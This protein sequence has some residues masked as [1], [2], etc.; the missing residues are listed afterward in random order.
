MWAIPEKEAKELAKETLH[1]L[2]PIAH[3]LGMNNIKG[4][5]EDLSLRYYKPDIYFSI[6]EKLNRTKKE[7]DDIVKEMIENVSK[8]LNDH[9]IEHK[10]KGRSKSIYSIYKKLDKGKKFEDIYDLLALRVYVEK[11][12]E[13]YQALGYIHEKFKPM[14]KR[15][16][17]YIAMPKTNMYQSLHTTVF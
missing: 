14:P 2:A 13:C 16:K 5:L 7:R 10:I 1:I 3:R 11:K 9:G 8:I 15:F 6:V 12:E 17:D 4:E